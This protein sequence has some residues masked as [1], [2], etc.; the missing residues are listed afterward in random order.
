MAWWDNYP[1]G[2]I[3][4]DGLWG[5]ETIYALQV[6][7]RRYGFY[8]W[9]YNLDGIEGHITRTAMQ[10]YLRWRGFYDGLIDG[11]LGPMSCVAMSYLFEVRAGAYISVVSGTFPS[12]RL[13]YLWQYYVNKYRNHDR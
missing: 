1:D 13:V 5:K 11:D 10:K 7:F 6:Y 4:A 9:Q 12:E 8:G 3:T 2:P